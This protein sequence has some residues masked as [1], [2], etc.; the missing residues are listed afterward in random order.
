MEETGGA[1]SQNR[2]MI[3]LPLCLLTLNCRILQAHWTASSQKRLLALMTKSVISST[4]MFVLI[5]AC[6][7]CS[8]IHIQ[9]FLFIWQCCW[10]SSH[11]VSGI[12]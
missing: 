9:V 4:G 3:S 5:Y 7:W 8:H 10:V 2:V 11:E 1:P 12:V 6:F